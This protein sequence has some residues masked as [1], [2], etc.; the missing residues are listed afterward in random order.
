[1]T[2]VFDKRQLIVSPALAPLLG[3]ADEFDSRQD[4]DAVL[5]IGLINNMPDSALQATE[6]QFMRLLK[7]AAG[8]NRI[9]LHCF[10]LPSVHRS[11]TAKWRID[12]QYTD[13]AHIGRLQLDGLIVT[14]AEPKAVTLP[15]ESFWQDLIEIVDWAEMNTRSTIWSCLAAHAAVL[16][17][18]GIERQRLETK[19]SGVYDCAKV[20]DDWLTRDIPSPLKISHSRFNGLRKSDLAARGYQLLTQ[21]QQAGVDIFAKQLRSYFVF[22]QGH[23]EYDALSLQREYLRDISW[24]LAGE[25][26]SFPAVPVGY[27]DAETE[28]NL[29]SFQKKA[30]VER[31]PAV[32]A[33]LPDIAI[34]Q[35]IAAGVAATVIFRNWLDYLSDGARAMSLSDN[36]G[37]PR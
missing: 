18:D 14:G 24:F 7:A 26:D 25:R 36:G 21:S 16:H 9:H 30:S 23:P 4:A 22:F 15:Q 31:K 12:R 20:V 8:N 1:M 32:A 37:T 35:D 28:N 34:R 13:I 29:A 2:L 33:E 27:F 19:C 10:S 11:Q 6:R 5:T 17:L 3:D